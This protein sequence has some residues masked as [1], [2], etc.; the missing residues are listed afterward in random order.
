M[1]ESDGDDF[2]GPA[3]SADFA[4]IFA[5]A[6]M[7]GAAEASSSTGK[8]KMVDL[9]DYNPPTQLDLDWNVE[10]EKEKLLEKTAAYVSGKKIT[11][12][13]LVGNID[14]ELASSLYE[15]T[16][17]H[18]DLENGG[19]KI[20]TTAGKKQVDTV[21]PGITNYDLHVGEHD[22]KAHACWL[23]AST[24]AGTFARSFLRVPSPIAATT[25]D[26]T[27]TQ[28]SIFFFSPSGAVTVTGTVLKVLSRS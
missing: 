22:Q 3:M 1:S 24:N 18:M 10:V 7:Q 28:S 2:S 16:L 6:E 8:K 23:R 20:T 13:A 5:L 11:G 19:A 27:E 25:M 12:K 17:Q 26:H 9:S 21:L 4:S 15:S 14:K